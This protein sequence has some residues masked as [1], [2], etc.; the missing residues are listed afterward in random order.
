[1]PSSRR[2]EVLRP[3]CE[4]RDT[5]MLTAEF[6]RQG[7]VSDVTRSSSIL[8]LPA[9]APHWLQDWEFAGVFRDE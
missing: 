5:S 2:G 4:E 3:G 7:V 9:P 8:R 6:L 1:M